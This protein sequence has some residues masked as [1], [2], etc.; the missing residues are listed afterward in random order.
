MILILYIA[1]V[2]LATILGAIAGL[3]GGVIIK[4]L[5]DMIGIHDASTIGFYSSCA[6]FTMC[7]VSIIKQVKKGFQFDIKTIIYISLGS[8]FGGLLGERTFQYITYSLENHT[9][10]M[11]QAILLGIT[12]ILIMIYT[13]QKNKFHHY[14]IK[15]KGSI[16]LTGLFLGSISIFLGIGGGPLNVATLMLM[17]SFSMKEATIY[18]IATIFFSQV[19]KLGSI[20]VQHQLLTYDLSFLPFICI[21]AIVG[22]Y[23]GTIFNQKFNEKE[24][25]KVYRILLILLIGISCYNV[26]INA[27]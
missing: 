10:K 1:I 8:L 12:L 24:I 17:F 2:L 19:S 20:I 13:L 25:E 15:N 22:G 6:V 27:I 7:I 18:S 16:F 5:F 4:P 3:G 9:V 23:I 21:S 26:Y 11:I 14:H